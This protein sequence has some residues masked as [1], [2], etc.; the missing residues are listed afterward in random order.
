MLIYVGVC[1]PIKLV[2]YPTIYKV[3]CN[4]IIHISVMIYE[5]SQRWDLLYS[6]MYCM[7]AGKVGCII[8]ASFNT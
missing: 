3:Q 7:Y 5:Q 1:M 6:I 8:H 2:I 4:N